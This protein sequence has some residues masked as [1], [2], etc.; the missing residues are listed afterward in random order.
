M[1]RS[2]N[3]QDIAEKRRNKLQEMKASDPEKYENHL[4]HRREYQR[5]RYA[6]MKNAEKRL[7]NTSA[8]ENDA[9]DVNIEELQ[10]LASKRQKLL[11]A[12]NNYKRRKWVQVPQVWDEDYPCM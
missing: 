5:K 8:L 10:N 7:L 11:D 3:S 12:A 9:D 2:E 1:Y 6:E 4:A